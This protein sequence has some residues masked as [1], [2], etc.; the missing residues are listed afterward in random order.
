MASLIT[1][2]SF[3]P[4]KDIPDLSGKVYVVTGASAGIGFGIAAHILQ[5]NPQKLYILSNKEH[6]ADEAI[7]ELKEWGDVSKVERK[8]MQ[9]PEFQGDRQR[10]GVGPYNITKDGVDS[11]MQVNF[12]SQFHLAMILLPILQKTP[13]S[14][15]A[16]QSSELHRPIGS[17]GKDSHVEFR[18]LDEINRDIG[19]TNLYNR[20][21]LAQIPFVRALKRQKDA[22][23]L[24]F[25]GLA[26]E[27]PWTNAA[28]PGAVST[29]QPE[30]AV[31]AYGIMGKAGVTLTRP[32]MSDPVKT[33]CRS[34]LFAATSPDVETEGLWGE[35]IIPDHKVSDP[36]SQAKDEELQERLWSLTE[37][38]LK[39]KLG[40]LPY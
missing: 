11:H 14:R 40:S 8:R 39:E 29:D 12:F 6:H 20:T 21:K 30:Q 15:L 37:S 35:Y 34:I 19:P 32:F 31:D 13:H 7:E 3:N 36:S 38:V 27:A 9:S 25:K 10:I 28:H 16:L 2:N 26:D 23:Q 1:G 17:A 4:D 22:K 33:G 24:G 5:H 18:D